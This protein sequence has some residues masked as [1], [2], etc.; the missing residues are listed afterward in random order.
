[1]N[2][3]NFWSTALCQS[4]LCVRPRL[5]GRDEGKW[6]KCKR[7]DSCIGS[8][9][10]RYHTQRSTCF[11]TLKQVLQHVHSPPT[12]H[13]LL[14][15]NMHMYVV[16]TYTLTNILERCI[17]DACRGGWGMVW[18]RGSVDIK[19]QAST[20]WRCSSRKWKH[21]FDAVRALWGLSLT[22]HTH[23]QGVHRFRQACQN[24]VLRVSHWHSLN[25]DSLENTVTFTGPTV[26]CV[27]RFLLGKKQ[28]IWKG[29]DSGEFLCVGRR[30]VSCPQRIVMVKVSLSGEPSHQHNPPQM[31]L[32]SHFLWLS[33]V[34]LSS[35][36]FLCSQM[37]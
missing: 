21:R 31:L 4:S 34:L 1:M 19:R 2:S 3:N 8:P 11:C 37:K 15:R 12:A 23:S 9:I 29:K 27:S 17:D 6:G 13:T 30:H 24:W 10:R 32:K 18:Q 36:A 22:L 35:V 28:I 16:C 26:L 25:L 20:G 33:A 14:T 7:R 5:T